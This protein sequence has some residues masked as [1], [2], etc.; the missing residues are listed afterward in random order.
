MKY[1]LLGK[2]KLRVPSPVEG[3]LCGEYLD[4]FLSRRLSQIR[5]WP[6]T[7]ETLSSQRLS[8]LPNRETAIGRKTPA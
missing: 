8:V 3:R 5:T 2:E 7:S 4:E 6:F 1:R